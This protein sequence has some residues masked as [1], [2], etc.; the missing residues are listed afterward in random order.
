MTRGALVIA[1]LVVLFGLSAAAQG[2][3][4]ETA[5][6]SPALKGR[7]L[8]STLS[9]MP[10]RF[11]Q[12]SAEAGSATIFLLDKKVMISI[13]ERNKTYS[14]ITFDELEKSLR[15]RG[16]ARERKIEESRKKIDALPE[17][18][19]KM[20]AP[21]EKAPPLPVSVTTRKESRTISGFACTGYEIRQGAKVVTTIWASTAVPG[22]AAMQKD[23]S[24]F[25]RR[26]AAMD[27]VNGR[28]MAE[29]MHKV[30]GFPILTEIGERLVTTVVKVEQRSTPKAAFEVPAGYQKTPWPF[31]H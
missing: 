21:T 27:P 5:T 20:I 31:L 30:S 13:N 28:A 15:N 3:V 1:A 19:R 17:A 18:Q 10:G 9:Y 7:T 22:Y 26:L 29:A 16:E 23:M 14:Q 6:T 25:S 2:L 11:R 12:T 8:A 24:D 4:W